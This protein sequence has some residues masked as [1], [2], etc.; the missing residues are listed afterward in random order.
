M[1]ARSCLWLGFAALLAG[2]CATSGAT[3]DP[4]RSTEVS[5]EVLRGVVDPGKGNLPTPPVHVV[6]DVTSL[7]GENERAASAKADA[8]LAL[9]QTAAPSM[10]SWLAPGRVTLH[11][12]DTLGKSEKNACGSKQTSFATQALIA[13]HADFES[14]SEAA[15]ARVLLVSDL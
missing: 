9:V 6:V 13:L 4:A 5:V 11:A 14:R 10:A 8:Q 1:N 7:L 15:D 12:F 2:G 3:R